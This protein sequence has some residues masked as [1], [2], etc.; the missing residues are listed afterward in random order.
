MTRA[1]V[2]CVLSLAIPVLAAASAAQS[3][4]SP[5][6]CLTLR[7]GAFLGIRTLAATSSGTPLRP[8]AFTAADFDAACAGPT[9]FNVAPFGSWCPNL[10]ADP[11]AEWIAVSPTRS[12][13][14]AL[15]CQ[16]FEIPECEVQY[17]TLRF[18]FCADNRLGDPLGGPNPVGVYLNGAP[19]AGFDTGG[20]LGSPTTWFHSDVSFL[21]QPGTNTLHVY[22]RDT[23][24]VAAGV[25]YSAQLCYLPCLAQERIRLRSGNGATGGPDGA[26]RCLP[27]ASSAPLR[28]APFTSGDFA[29]ACSFPPAQVVTPFAGWCPTLPQD[30]AAQWIAPAQGWPARSALY[31]HPFTVKSCSIDS[32]TLTLSWAADNR[33]G[34]A[35]GPN[36]MGV[37]VNG[38]PLPIS[39][40]AFG[41]TIATATVPIPAA[42]L[43]PGANVLHVYNRDETGFA[44]GVLYT[45]LLTIT[46]CRVTEVVTIRSGNGTIGGPDS[47]VRFLG[48]VSHDPLRAAP[49]TTQDFQD[50]CAAPAQVVTPWPT[51]C[52]SL[53]GDPL[54][55]WISTDQERGPQ[56]AL[57][58]H[59]FTIQHCKRVP[60][61]LRFTWRADNRLGDPLGGPNLAGVYV[62]GTPVPSISGG[63]FECPENT[64]V[65]NVVLDPGPNRLHVYVRDTSGTVSGVIYSAR[66]ETDPRCQPLWHIGAA[67][68]A[69]AA[70]PTL[71]VT[72]APVL[73]GSLDEQIHGAIANT[74]AL[75]VIGFSDST[76]GGLRLPMDL[77]P[78]GGQNCALYA[79]M[80]IVLPVRI[81]GSGSGSSRVPIPDLPE[82]AG[83]PLY[84]QAFV[85]DP[86]ANPL[87]IA[88]TQAWGVELETPVP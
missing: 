27:G 53:A 13:F 45:A 67:C 20:G 25:I 66:F 33:L 87:G 15:Y 5:Y 26:I 80:E 48:G 61:K 76:F 16:T 44:S 55:R 2:R 69:P 8:G 9:A 36:P 72:S 56:T 81:D 12:P 83:L 60:G 14:S 52:S 11:I 57:F 51:W 54:A 10:A 41:C 3:V 29:L 84:T 31:C 7:S 37:Y 59:P 43:H 79:S 77:G 40:G 68:G 63:S 86:Q 35:G 24:A 32:A 64:V 49:F 73:G 85:I 71:A 38:T 28:P 65:A 88:A 46:P 17:A 75:M 19:V 82:L 78:F 39:G 18:T 4:P 21:L 74:S 30:P 6:K 58:C 34:D 62:N 70:T 22:V 1:R 50:A 47:Q 42:A 23:T